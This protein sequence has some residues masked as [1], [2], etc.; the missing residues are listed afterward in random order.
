MAV[1]VGT[2]GSAPV[3]I[4][5]NK[6]LIE[7][8]DKHI[9]STVTSTYLKA[10]G[11]IAKLRKNLKDQDLKFYS[12]MLAMLRSHHV[13]VVD[14]YETTLPKVLFTHL[15]CAIVGEFREAFREIE[16]GLK[17][18]IRRRQRGQPPL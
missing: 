2:L 3:L 17:E 7:M 9:T 18:N 13:A 11:D 6:M 15:R 12:R 14:K 4:S 16:E 1:D 5:I 10:R 8:Q